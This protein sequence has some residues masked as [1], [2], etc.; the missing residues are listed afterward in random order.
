MKR[1]KDA[2]GT[3]K[4]GPMAAVAPNP[5]EIH[6]DGKYTRIHGR[7]YDVSGFMDSH[8]GGPLA[9]SLG[10]G[11]DAT[12]LFESYHSLSTAGLRQT[13]LL[14]NMLIS[15]T[16]TLTAL[17]QRYPSASIADGA[18]DWTSAPSVLKN[19]SDESS[20]QKVDP[21]QRDVIDIA[22][23]YFSAEATRRG[24]SFREATKA[25][26][27]RWLQIALMGLLAAASFAA[28]LSGW[29][30]AVF[31]APISMWILQA[32]ILRDVAAL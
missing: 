9:L 26:P 19:A 24:V 13:Y 7:W 6:I 30:S 23:K 14:E 22:R 10:I 11:R 8:P 1:S 31:L 12:A 25:T 3:R 21:F 27:W 29:W 15:D 5:P 2:Q 17:E 18:F 4:T 28:L 16:A 20:L 32:R